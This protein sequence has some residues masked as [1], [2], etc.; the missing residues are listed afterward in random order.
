MRPAPPS[1]AAAAP[2]LEAVDCSGL[3]SNFGPQERELRE[4]F[5]E[6]FGV[7]ASRVAMVANATLGLSGAVVIL[8][9]SRW[10]VPVFTFAATPAAVLAAGA[11]VMFADV[12]VDV[13]LDSGGLLVDG[14]MPVAPFGAPPDLERW[15]GA[16]RVVHDAAAALGNDMDLSGL[17]ARQAVVF[18]LHAT[19]VLGAGEGGVVVFGDAADAAR[20]R[21]WTNF[22]FSGSREAQVAGVNAKMSEIQACYAHAALDGWEQEQAEWLAARERVGRMAAAVGVELLR[23]G[24]GVNPYA[25]VEFPDAGTPRRVE[26]TLERHGVGTRRWWAM[27]CHRMPAYAHLIDAAF[28]VT[29]DIAARTLGLP[30]YRGMTNEEVE[31][32]RVA[33]EEAL[34]QS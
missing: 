8:G 32:V 31:A 30:M 27:G 3:Y 28:P 14:L 21:A 12:G 24:N 23:F 18:S 7:E 17:P 11:E 33:L 20:F 10:A 22:G 5:A 19:K 16:G 2:R 34:A 25:I 29:D 13:V 1:F 4:R 6:R 9:G 15:S 26:T